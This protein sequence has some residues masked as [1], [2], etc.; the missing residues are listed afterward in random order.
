MASLAASPRFIFSHLKN[1]LINLFLQSLST[2]N[3]VA[4]ASEGACSPIWKSLPKNN[5]DIELLHL[6]VY[7]GNP[8]IHLYQR[9]GFVQYGYQRHFIKQNGQYLGKIMM[10]KALGSVPK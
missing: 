8:A 7:E 9:L 1:W 2:K 3:I 10:Q 6:E 4:K 5:F